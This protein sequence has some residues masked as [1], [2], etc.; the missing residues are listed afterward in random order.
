[1][2]HKLEIEKPDGRKFIQY[3]FEPFKGQLEVLDYGVVRPS[4]WEPPKS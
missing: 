3:S 2:L 4:S 1:M